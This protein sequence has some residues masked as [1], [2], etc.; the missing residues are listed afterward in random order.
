MSYVNSKIK[1]NYTLNDISD[2]VYDGSLLKKC[3]ITLNSIECQISFL[4]T[5]VN[6]LNE[7]FTCPIVLSIPLSIDNSSI[8][9]GNLTLKQ[10]CNYK[11]IKL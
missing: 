10:K 2:I 9:D 3:N 11:F 1:E 6:N 8:Y 7:K 5:I 4:I